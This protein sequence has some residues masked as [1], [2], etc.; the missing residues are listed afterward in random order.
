MQPTAIERLTVQMLC[1]IYK[2]LG[3][4]DS[5]DPD[6]V[7]SAIASN[8][9]WVLDWAY[10]IKDENTVTPPHVTAVVNTLDMYAFL[11]DSFNGLS[12]EDRALVEAEIPR[13]S[14]QVEFRGYDGNNETEYRS[15]ARYL[16]KDLERF[17]SMREVATA[18]SHC[19]VVTMY[20]RMYQVFEPIRATLIDRLMSPQE[21][22]AVLNAAVHP[23]NR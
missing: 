9:L 21:I 17:Q 11:R 18:N 2:K 15:A 14:H 22:T 1:A 8:N 23:D 13:A 5:F 10:D 3:I 4:E 16:V 20:A 12:A 7:S 6:L 19:P